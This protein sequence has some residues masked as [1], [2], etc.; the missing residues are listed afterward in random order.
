ML[1]SK[2]IQY[3]ESTKVLYSLKIK[4]K[5]EF[6]VEELVE[7]FVIGYRTVLCDCILSTKV[8]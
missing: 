2:V 1:S 7:C 4:V 3:S 8:E 5:I 6:E